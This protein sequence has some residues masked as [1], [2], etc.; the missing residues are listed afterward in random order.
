MLYATRF[1]LTCPAIIDGYLDVVFIPVMDN[2]VTILY[3]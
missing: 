3:F 2:V 1:N